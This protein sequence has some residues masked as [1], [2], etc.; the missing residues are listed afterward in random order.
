MS[1]TCSG[2]DFNIHKKTNE[3]AE[4]KSH[5]CS[6]LTVIRVI[7]YCNYPHW[8][9]HLLSEPH[10]IFTRV[11]ISSD[12]CMEYPISPENIITIDSQIKW[13]LWSNFCQGLKQQ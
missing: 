7:G 4:P 2:E 6:E 3:H 9:W 1:Y 10:N 5:G 8:S 11:F 13:M 12:N